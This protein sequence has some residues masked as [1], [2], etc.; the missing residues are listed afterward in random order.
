MRKNLIKACLLWAIPFAVFAVESKSPEEQITR[1]YASIE[2]YR[3]DGWDIEEYRTR[4]YFTS[5]DMG[6]LKERIDGN[7]HLE[8]L[9]TKN[10]F[11][12]TCQV[13]TVSEI[14]REI[15][16][17]QNV[18]ETVFRNFTA[19]VNSIFPRFM[20]NPSL[21]ILLETDKLYIQAEVSDL[22]A[23]Y[24]NLV[25]MLA[26]IENLTRSNEIL[27]RLSWASFVKIINPENKLLKSDSFINFIVDDLHHSPGIDPAAD[28]LHR[29][30]VS[31][32]SHAQ[33]K[34]DKPTAMAIDTVCDAIKSK[35]AEISDV[36]D[37]HSKEI[38]RIG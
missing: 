9:Q 6:L 22:K 25:C 12:K 2:E 26:E 7:V 19:R 31:E 36:L 29:S 1:T 10:P 16:D 32:E 18:G 23:Y 13:S 35:M 4:E 33:S 3:S 27:S 28:Y 17:P 8:R 24:D 14:F 38:L 21:E 5:T 11:L 37:Y 15:S 20:Y 34:K 30:S